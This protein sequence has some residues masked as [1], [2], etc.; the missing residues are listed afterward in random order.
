MCMAVTIAMKSV[1]KSYLLTNQSFRYNTEISSSFYTKTQLR[2]NSTKTGSD[3][4]MKQEEV[5][6]QEKSYKTLK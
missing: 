4:M 3:T 2:G 6:R 5:L 1:L